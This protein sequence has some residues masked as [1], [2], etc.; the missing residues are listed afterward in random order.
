MQQQISKEMEHRYTGSSKE[1][2]VH[3]VGYGGRGV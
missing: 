2:R 3:K 1:G